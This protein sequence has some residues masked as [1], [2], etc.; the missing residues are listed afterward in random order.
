MNT[1][2]KFFA[3]LLT[4]F[5]ALL[6]T[7]LIVYIALAHNPQ[8]EFLAEDGVINWMDLSY[9]ILPFLGIGM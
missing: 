6:P 9:L 8:N 4:V 5:A 1:I 2:E 3:A 7:V